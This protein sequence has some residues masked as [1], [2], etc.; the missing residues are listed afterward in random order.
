MVSKIAQQ[1][2]VAERL[3]EISRRD[4]TGGLKML[5]CTHGFKDLC[6][7]VLPERKPSYG[8]WL[9]MSTWDINCWN[10]KKSGGMVFAHF[11]DRCPFCEH[12][13]GDP[14]LPLRNYVVGQQT[15]RDERLLAL[16]LLGEEKGDTDGC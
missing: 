7:V 3:A 4:P 9:L 16:G 6:V 5:D 10:C 11:I 14:D 2:T 13:R 8:R 1:P 15:I 12:K